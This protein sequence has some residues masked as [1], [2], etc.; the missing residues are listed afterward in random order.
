MRM[1]GQTGR[2]EALLA[3]YSVDPSRLSN[4][5]QAREV[6]MKLR[7]NGDAPSARRLL[8]FFYDRQ[9]ASGDLSI[10]NF[11]GL[12]EVLLE[13]DNTT[14]AVR[15]LKRMALVTQPAFAGL[16]DSGLL[17]RRF[18]K[19][20][21]AAQFLEDAVKAVPWDA[22]AKEALSAAATPAAPRTLAQLEAD[23]R[24]DPAEPSLKLALFRA[25]RAAGRH[26][27]S[28]NAIEVMHGNSL[29]PLFAMEEVVSAE[30]H[31]NSYWA[32]SFL[33]MVNLA[34]AE[35]A[36]IAREVS[37]SLAR[38]ERPQGA[39]VAMQ[40]AEK[41]EPSAQNRTRIAALRAELRRQ[42]T[43]RERRP[44]VAETLDQ[45]KIVRP[46]IAAAGGAR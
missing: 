34:N 30:P 37:D 1:A 44:L 14:E 46:M 9:I 17:L 45:E 24:N 29:G 22:S 11:L 20:A 6:S 31:F 3:E 21:E 13:E 16:K 43:N 8:R 27:L 41:L 4:P 12:T 18:K 35:R 5:Y 39:L 36:R 25:A 26:R 33:S 42:L 40:I 7:E 28:T 32:E 2:L 10:A 19:D 38:T 15:Q 23:V